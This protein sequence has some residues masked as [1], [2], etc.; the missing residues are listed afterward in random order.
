MEEQGIPVQGC[1]LGVMLAEHELGRQYTRALLSAAQSMQ[2]GDL[3]ANRRAIQC[4]LSYITLLRLHINKEDNILLSM[5]DKVIPVDQYT[6]I[7]EDFDHFEHAETGEGL[8]EKFLV[9]AKTL[10]DEIKA[11]S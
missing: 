5:A 7:W 1:P 2:S 6:S 11:Y 3:S 10:E 4:S 9:L 8:H